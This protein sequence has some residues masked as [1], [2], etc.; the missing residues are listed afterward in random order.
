LITA[1]QAIDLR[2]GRGALGAG[3]R[4]VYEAIRSQVAFLDQDR[5]L[6]GDIAA[7]R[8]MIKRSTISVPEL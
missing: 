5:P 1:C 2:G 7:V 8:E 3:N 6:D 4:D